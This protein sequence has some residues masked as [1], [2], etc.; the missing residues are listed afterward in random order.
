METLYHQMDSHT[1]KGQT[2]LDLVY[3]DQEKQC[4]H[5][6]PQESHFHFI[7]PTQS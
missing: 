7:G 5:Y 4:Y 6:A 2:F 3:L 1:S